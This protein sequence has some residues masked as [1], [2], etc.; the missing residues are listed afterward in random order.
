MKRKSGKNL[1][2]FDQKQL[3]KYKKLVDWKAKQAFLGEML[4]QLKKHKFNASKSYK[5]FIEFARNAVL[6]ENNN[7]VVISLLQLI[8]LLADQVYPQ[9]QRYVLQMFEF[10]VFKFTTNLA[11]LEGDLTRPADADALRPDSLVP[12]G[13][14]LFSG[15]PHSDA[16]FA[17]TQSVCARTPAQGH[18]DQG[19]LHLQKER[20]I[21]LF[22]GD[23]EEPV[24]ADVECQQASARHFFQLQSVSDQAGSDGRNAG[25][26]SRQEPVEVIQ[27]AARQ[28]N[29]QQHQGSAV[30][31]EKGGFSDQKTDPSIGDDAKGEQ[32]NGPK[33]VEGHSQA[34]LE[35]AEGALEGQ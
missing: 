28:A 34:V 35:S 17:Q 24:Q 4:T 33:P 15:D 21:G 11:Q 23:Q 14:D 10:L 3:D 26:G 19:G 9:V 5:D 25:F 30:D 27:E 16:P 7:Q 18:R 31:P 29:Q 32:Q 2:K 12:H 8:K 13:K 1:S 6:R 20:D 22:G